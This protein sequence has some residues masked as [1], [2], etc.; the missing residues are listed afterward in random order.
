MPAWFIFDFLWID[1]IMVRFKCVR[2][3]IVNRR[4]NVIDL[5]GLCTCFRRFHHLLYLPNSLSALQISTAG[6]EKSVFSVVCLISDF[7]TVWRYSFVLF[8]S[9]HFLFC[10]ITWNNFPVPH[11]PKWKGRCR[12]K[13]T[14]LICKSNCFAAFTTGFRTRNPYFD[15]SWEQI[16]LSL[17]LLIFMWYVRCFGSSRP[18]WFCFMCTNYYFVWMYYIL[19]LC[20][21]GVQLTMVGWHEL[22]SQSSNA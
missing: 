8:F 5:Y 4:A 3:S 1:S 7:Y 19:S 13:G 6:S 9:P 11:Y 2:T 20:C 22:L 16:V 14:F 15:A 12:R 17:G 18:K 21:R 10:V